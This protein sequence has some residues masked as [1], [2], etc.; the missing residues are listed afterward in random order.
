MAIY[1]VK[2]RH[3]KRRKITR[4]SDG[5]CCFRR[6]CLGWRCD[7]LESRISGELKDRRP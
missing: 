3:T 6:L 4:L 7:Y 1:E 2:D 5:R